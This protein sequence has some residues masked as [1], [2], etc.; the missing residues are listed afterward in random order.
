MAGH[1]DPGSPTLTR[2]LATEAEVLT[3]YFVYMA[4]VILAFVAYRRLI[5]AEYAVG[6]LQVGWGLMEALILAKVVL[7]GKK[8]G[9]G[10]RGDSLPLVIPILYRAVLFSLLTVV[11]MVLEEVLV[12]LVHGHPPA[13]ALARLRHMNRDEALART[14]VMF[15]AFVPFFAFQVLGS[16][17]GLTE[18]DVFDLLFRTGTLPPRHPPGAAGEVPP[19]PGDGRT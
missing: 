14:I 2:R 19:G 4:S 18:T 15:V 8:M 17:I 5:L 1:K 10:K 9:L 13:A 16:R 3:L 6:Y 7:L 11:F 12:G